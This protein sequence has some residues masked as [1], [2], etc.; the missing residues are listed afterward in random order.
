MLHKVTL[1]GAI[2]IPYLIYVYFFLCFPDFFSLRLLILSFVACS[3]SVLMA[4][5]RLVRLLPIFSR[6]L[7]VSDL[8]PESKGSRLSPAATYMQR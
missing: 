3:T 1:Q 6:S 4:V 5:V 7:V 8:H 2:K